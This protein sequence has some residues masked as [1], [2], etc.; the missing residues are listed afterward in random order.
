[1]NVLRFSII[2]AVLAIAAGVFLVKS[3]EFS[4]KVLTVAIG[5][6]FILSGVVSCAEY[7]G[8]R[9]KRNGIAV[10]DANGNMLPDVRPLFPVVG[11]GSVLLGIILSFLPDMF[12]RYMMYIFGAILIFGAVNQ[13]LHL[14]GASKVF[15]LSFVYW[16][17]PSVTFLAG[18]YV[19][20]N[21]LEAAGMPMVVAGFALVFYGVTECINGVRI[22]R[23][24]KNNG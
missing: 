23:G 14:A 9:F 16:V 24:M 18:C 13:F 5:L 2:R 12:I 19:L 20:A 11:F 7:F 6:C 21:P 4:V 3:P 10:Y 17:F 8:L 15:R 1:M 22:Y